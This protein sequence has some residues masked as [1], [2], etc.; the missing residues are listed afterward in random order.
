MPGKKSLTGKKLKSRP[1]L[2]S[3]K[4]RAEKEKRRRLREFSKGFK[5][6]NRKK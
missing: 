4:D 2:G 1:A 3:R 6:R 5:T